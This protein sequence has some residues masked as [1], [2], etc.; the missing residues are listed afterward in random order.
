[1]S[2]NLLNQGN[3]VEYLKSILDSIFDE[4]M[5]YIPED[6]E[7]TREKVEK[8]VKKSPVK[9]NFSFNKGMIINFSVPLDSC[10]PLAKTKNV[11]QAITT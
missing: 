8:L 3:E 7:V 2:E 5:I 4:I 1:M 11:L 6:I 9:L 10:G